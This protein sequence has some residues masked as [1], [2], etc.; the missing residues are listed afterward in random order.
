MRKPKLI[1]AVLLM[2]A[3][4]CLAGERALVFWGGVRSGAPGVA[5]I[6]IKSGTGVSGIARLLRAEGVI[7]RADLYPLLALR[8]GTRSS[9]RAGR[10][11]IDLPASP[12]EVMAALCA[13]GAGDGVMIPEGRTV[14][15]IGAQLLEANLIRSESDWLAVTAGP[16]HGFIEAADAPSHEGFCF[17]DTYLFGVGQ[18]AA[19]IRDVMVRR[20]RAVWESL[21]PNRRDPRARDLTLNQIVTL[22]SMVER[23]TRDPTEYPAIAAV[24]LN[25]L[26]RRMKL[27]CCATVRHALG[28]VWNRPLTAEDLKIDSP[29]NTYRNAGLPPGA[30]CNPGR[31]A[32]EAV[33]RPAPGGYL[34][35]VH[36]G[37]GTHE[38]NMTYEE[39]VRAA[40]EFRDDL[41]ERNSG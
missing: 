24:Y 29:F 18:D 21:N 10:F 17:P 19:A 38:F 14:A 16:P 33:L 27:Q 40:R 9:H 34:Y 6:S 36:R 15:Q 41:R 31:A 26:E 20:F 12:R 3:L 23:E 13:R 2:L 39:H 32:L 28:G 25:R 30:I 37:D 22:A 1:P 7:S 4:A 5:E 8:E 11:T 35:Y